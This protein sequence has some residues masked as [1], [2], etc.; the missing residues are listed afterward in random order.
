M[1]V[2]FLFF[3]FVPFSWLAPP[4]GQKPCL[5]VTDG[6]P[7]VSSVYNKCKILTTNMIAGVD[8][9]FK[10]RQQHNMGSFT[11]EATTVS[12]LKMDENRLRWHK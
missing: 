8:S 7:A 12:S 2:P 3:F 10:H 5:H 9:S 4:P 11:Q 6:L 1:E